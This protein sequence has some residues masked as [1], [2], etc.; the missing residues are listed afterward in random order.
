MKSHSVHGLR[1][2][3]LLD[4]LIAIVVV[5][6]GIFGVAKLNSNLLASTGLAKT[7]ASA[8][9]CAAAKIDECRTSP[10][11]YTD[12]AGDTDDGKSCNSVNAVFTRKWTFLEGNSGAPDSI[13]VEVS[14][15]SE[16]AESIRLSSFIAKADIGS[17]AAIGS[18]Q[19]PKC[20][21]SEVGNPMGSAHRPGVEDDLPENPTD[22]AGVDGTFVFSE[23]GKNY[24]V[25]ASSN[26]VLLVNDGTAFSSVEGNV[27]ITWGSKVGIENEEDIT[28][29]VINDNV[30][31]LASAGA[32]C[33]QYMDTGGADLLRYPVSGEINYSYFNYRCYMGSGWFGNIGI[34]RY[35]KGDRVCLGDPQVIKSDDVDSRHAY[36]YP[37]RNYRGYY[38]VEGMLSAALGIGMTTPDGSYS[39]K[40]YRATSTEN[41]HHFLLTTLRGTPANA[42]CKLAEAN[43]SATINPFT[44]IS[45]SSMG[46]SGLLFCLTDEC[47]A[48]VMIP[49]LETDFVLTI[50]FPEN[51]PPVFDNPI[52]FDGGSCELNSGSSTSTSN[53][54]DCKIYWSGWA[55]DFW[56]GHLV[57]DTAS[58]LGPEVSVDAGTIDINRKIQIDPID[59]DVQWV[60]FLMVPK[61]VSG[62]TVSV[63]PTVTAP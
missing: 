26:K 10:C 24:L 54:Y 30:R 53:S 7:R 29:D 44:T 38:Y 62:F 43:I 12:T 46:N 45:G 9:Q 42:D 63:T 2:F 22:T 23:G 32:A 3:V 11:P 20:I 41:A 57:F 51:V 61:E 48:V 13:T 58:R 28:M 6:I 55:G 5:A 34:V 50:N 17:G 47:E 31:V 56:S 59:T 1:G 14:W 18:G 39:P 36:L 49:S 60:D 21:S 37:L 25:N 35:D 40:S 4:A 15:P 52:S 16:E 19:T 8:I 33:V 27:Y